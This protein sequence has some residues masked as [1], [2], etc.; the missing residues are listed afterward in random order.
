MTSTKSASSAVAASCCAAGLLLFSLQAYLAGDG[1]LF[2]NIRIAFAIFVASWVYIALLCLVSLAIS[3]YVKWK[4]VARL[5]LF[6]VFVVASGFSQILNVALRT[7]W[8]SVINLPDMMRVVWSS[9]FGV[10]FWTDVVQTP[11]A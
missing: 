8:G 4:P 11:C 2:D 5:G 7:Q 6:G 9:L 1:W 3:A 10:R